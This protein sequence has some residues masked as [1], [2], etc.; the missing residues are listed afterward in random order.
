MNV[1]ESAML[2]TSGDELSQKGK[3]KRRK[4]RLREDDSEESPW[5][6]KLELRN[7]RAEPHY[8]KMRVDRNIN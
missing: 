6:I 5:H 7:K 3:E 8:G 4:D 1:V 2:L